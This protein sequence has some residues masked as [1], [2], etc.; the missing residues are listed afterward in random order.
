MARINRAYVKK[1]E[2]LIVQL[3][4]M[5]SHIETAWEKGYLTRDI[6]PQKRG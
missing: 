1:M 4:T 3:D 5:L 2:D 6:G